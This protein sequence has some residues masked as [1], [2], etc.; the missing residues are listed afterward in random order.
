MNYYNS[1]YDVYRPLLPI[2]QHPTFQG[3]TP[4]FLGG[5]QVGTSSWF[6]P[7]YSTNYCYAAGNAYS[8][9]F[10]LCD[11]HNKYLCQDNGQWKHVTSC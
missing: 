5:H 4:T 2:Q 10:Y 7:T 6:T 1:W 11:N 9:G 8:P 3:S